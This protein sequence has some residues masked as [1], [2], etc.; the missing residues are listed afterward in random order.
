LSRSLVTDPRPGRLLALGDCY[1]K[2][3]ATASA[4]ATF[5]EAKSLARQAGLSV[6]RNG[7]AV[8]EAA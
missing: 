4:W 6:K 7:K 1:E 5:R 2:A 8:E 3:G